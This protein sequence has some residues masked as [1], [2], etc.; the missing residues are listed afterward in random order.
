MSRRPLPSG[1][2]RRTPAAGQA[3]SAATK[4]CRSASASHTSA[5]GEF[6]A[7]SGEVRARNKSNAPLLSRSA[8]RNRTSPARFFAASGTCAITAASQSLPSFLSDNR[9]I[10]PSSCTASKSRTPS[11]LAS[12]T[13][14]AFTRG[15]L[16]RQQRA[17]EI[18]L[19]RS[20]MNTC[21]LP[22][23]SMI[24]ASGLPSPSKSAHANPR[25]PEIPR[26]RMNRQ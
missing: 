26:K 14:M 1:R 7:A 10:F 11:L 5:P 19:A 20:F 23:P 2:Q 13:L 18:S 25:T 22:A 16:P 8:T 3:A 4:N 24:A 6:F 17:R 12:A 9:T 21:S 15:K